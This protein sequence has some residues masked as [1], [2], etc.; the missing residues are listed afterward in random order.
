MVI[1]NP[2]LPPKNGYVEVE[3]ESERTYQNIA[4][5]RLI[6]EE[7]R[8]PTTIEEIRADRL[9]KLDGM[10][11]G[12]IYVGLDIGAKHYSFTQL[13]QD[14]IKGLMQEIQQGATVVPYKADGEGFTPHTAEQMTT[15]AKAMSEWIKVNTHYYD[16]LKQWVERETNEAV[17]STIR[18]GSALPADLMQTLG[19]Q[20]AQYSIDIRKYVAMLTE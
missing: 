9:N 2:Q 20:L 4:T 18:Y 10:C 3:I 7:N 15:I 19:T 1:T 14:S 6:N 8:L 5:G 17:I 11:S 12:A 13:A 16:L